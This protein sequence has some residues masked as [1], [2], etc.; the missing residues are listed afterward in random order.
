VKP[1]C[2][3]AL[4]VGF[5]FW[6]VSLARHTGGPFCDTSKMVRFR[7]G[8]VA[9]LAIVASAATTTLFLHHGK[10]ELTMTSVRNA[11]KVLNRMDN[12]DVA[13]ENGI[14]TLQLAQYS[15]KLRHRRRSNSAA[16]T[17]QLDHSDPFHHEPYDQV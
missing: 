9:I 11:Q 1:G 14:P 13:I 12:V 15:S 10:T 8:T 17:M 16:Q 7:W 3:R 5:A 4:K 2:A 6:V